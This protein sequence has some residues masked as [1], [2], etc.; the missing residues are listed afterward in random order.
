MV[1]LYCILLHWK[2]SVTIYR[3]TVDTIWSNVFN[4]QYAAWITMNIF[5]GFLTQNTNHFLSID[6]YR[7]E[8]QNGLLYFS[9]S[10]D[11]P[12]T[13]ISC[14]YSHSVRVF[15]WE[16]MSVHALSEE[17]VKQPYARWYLDWFQWYSATIL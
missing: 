14:L 3:A 2:V 1:H 12:S 7:R 4:S 9:D 8:T 10:L 17:K 11:W 16:T 13:S 15:L 5:S 6:I